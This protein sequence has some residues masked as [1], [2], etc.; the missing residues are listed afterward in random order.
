MLLPLYSYDDISKLLLYA[1]TPGK[2]D[3][4]FYAKIIPA[5]SF[6]ECKDESCKRN[7]FPDSSD[8]TSERQ[9]NT[10]Y[11]AFPEIA[12]SKDKYVVIRVM[13]STNDIVP[14]ATSFTTYVEST[15]PSHNYLQLFNVRPGFSQRVLL[16]EYS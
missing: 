8:L 7:L 15:V 11:F 14:I 13:S 5:T 1:N 2:N 6:E 16:D 3:V 12:L 4:R 9:E 10:K